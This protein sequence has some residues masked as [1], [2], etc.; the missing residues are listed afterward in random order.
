MKL[1][2]KWDKFIYGLFWKN[3][4]RHLGRYKGVEYFLM[5][6]LQDSTKDISQDL[7]DSATKFYN[8]LKEETK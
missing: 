6:Q 1:R 5:L 2:E 7:K 8:G 4:N 3:C